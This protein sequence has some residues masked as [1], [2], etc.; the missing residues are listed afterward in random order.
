MKQLLHGLAYVHREGLIHRDLKPANIFMVYDRGKRLRVLIGDF[1]LAIGNS[2]SR[3][4]SRMNSKMV[5]F[6]SGKLKADM[7]DSATGLEDLSF[8]EGVGTPTYAAPEQLEGKHLSPK[9]DIYSFGIIVVEL[10][11]IFDTMRARAKMSD[12]ARCT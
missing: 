12:D 3:R 2:I 5:A 8:E 6:S 7:P 4:V 1:G 10:C 9:A 11:N